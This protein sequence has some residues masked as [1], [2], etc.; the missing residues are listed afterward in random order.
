MFAGIR[1]GS[2]TTY[3]RWFPVLW[4]MSQPSLLR[5]VSADD[6]SQ[7]LGSAR[8][9]GN[10]PGVLVPMEL[11]LVAAIP[12]QDAVLAS[13]VVSDG[14]VFVIDGS[15]VVH[16]I[17][18]ETLQVRWTYRTRGGAGNCN[19]V[20]APAVIGNYLHVGTMA[21]Y[22]YVL[23][24]RTGG[25]V[26]EIDC[27]EP[28]FAAPVVGNDRVYFATLGARLFAVGPDGRQIWQWDFVKEVVQFDGNRWSGKGLAGIPRGS[29]DL[30]RSFRVF[31]RH[32]LDRQD[33]CNASRWTHRFRC[34]PR[35]RA[36]VG[37]GGRDSRLRGTGVSC[38][39]RS[40]R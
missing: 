38:D 22:Y 34:R 2:I 5:S 19:N 9:S 24:V 29:R 3:L 14:K 4:A 39:L 30:A 21:G 10:A 31:A 33:D 40:K 35:Q 7:L 6:W 8:H 36:S 12:L 18:A 23:D 26:R 11:G 13:P 15:G 27:A 16:A 20:A 1:W 37:G 25:V 32:L 17:D 28:I